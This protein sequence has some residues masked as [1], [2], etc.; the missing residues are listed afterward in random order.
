MRHIVLSALAVLAALLW[1]PQARA[2]CASTQVPLARD[3]Q[4]ITAQVPAPSAPYVL[5]SG[6]LTAPDLEKAFQS[7]LDE[8]Q[9][10]AAL[11]A[12][13]AD[14]QKRVLPG[15]V[16]RSM[17]K[18]YGVT[19]DFLPVDTLKEVV[20]ENGK[21]TFRFDFGGSSTRKV[22]LPDTS[23]TVLKQKNSADPWAA[24]GKNEPKVV[25]SKGRELKV[26]NEVQLTVDQTGITGIRE[27]DIEVGWALGW[28]GMKLHMEHQAGKQ[29]MADERPVIQTGAD[30][31]PL[32][33]NGHYVPQTYDDWV[34]IEAG[35]A[36]VEAGVPP[37]S[38]GSK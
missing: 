4:Q 16:V 13:L 29:A 14:G 8:K 1:A 20:A 28:L 11:F 19:I 9:G 10:L 38:T 31:K 30:G 32:V 18:K 7:I 35:P 23:S 36:R 34:V 5:P 12:L 21:V 22:K 25:T 17:F 2:Q 33:V 27:G 15:D 3:L 26:K 6:T 24:D 37:L